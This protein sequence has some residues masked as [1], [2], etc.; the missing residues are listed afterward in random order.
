M[1]G[2]SLFSNHTI[3]KRTSENPWLQASSIVSRGDQYA[4]NKFAEVVTRT[5]EDDDHAITA[6]YFKNAVAKVILFKAL[7]VLISNSHWYDGGIRA[8]IVTYSMA[9]LARLVSESKKHFDFNAVW[10]KQEVPEDLVAVLSEIAEA[11]YDDITRP[12]EGAANI[13]QWSKKEASWDRVKK[14]DLK[15]GIPD[16][17][18]LDRDQV[19]TQKWQGR[20]DKIIM[21]GIQIQSFVVRQQPGLW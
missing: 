12:A 21:S 1:I 9:Y 11:V 15:V 20:K 19:V 8:Q 3:D 5:I 16:V 7:K 18:L 4:F 13:A 2:Q 17:Y 10:E 14:L 6:S